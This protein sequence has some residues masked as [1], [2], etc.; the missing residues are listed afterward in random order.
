MSSNRNSKQTPNKQGAATTGPIG[1]D[2]DIW[3]DDDDEYW[4]EMEVVKE[5]VSVYGLDGDPRDKRYQYGS[6]TSASSPT[7]VRG[8]TYHNTI[9]HART[10]SA[11]TDE[12]DRNKRR[13]ETTV[14]EL[15]YTRL[16]LDEDDDTEEIHLRTRFLFDEDK[17]MTPLSQMQATKNLLTEA[18]RIAYVSVCYLACR[19][20]AVSWRKVGRKE[21]VPAV[22]ALETWSI[23]ILGRLYYH[24]EIAVPGTCRIVTQSYHPHWE[25]DS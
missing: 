17:A 13:D 14:H 4:Q 16:R 19:E 20:M 1:K 11:S 2:D 24:M 18:Q 25:G 7:L 10:S 15:D 22:K 5:E 6:P 3:N 9:S 21:L 8:T 12:H 23:K